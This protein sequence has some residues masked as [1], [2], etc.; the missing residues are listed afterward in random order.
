MTIVDALVNELG[1]QVSTASQHKRFATKDNNPSLMLVEF[2][3]PSILF[4]ALREANNLRG[5]EKYK[6]VYVSRDMTKTKRIV[7]KRLRDERNKRNSELTER[8]AGERPRGLHQGKL[9]L[10]VPVS[11]GESSTS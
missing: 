5:K 2:D 4:H 8:G 1:M 9:F 6:D 11:S 3:D 7:E 10:S